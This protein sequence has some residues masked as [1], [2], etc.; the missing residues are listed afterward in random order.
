MSSVSFCQFLR[1]KIP[2]IGLHIKMLSVVRSAMSSFIFCKTSWRWTATLSEMDQEKYLALVSFWPLFLPSFSLFESIHFRY[3]LP[4]TYAIVTTDQ[5]LYYSRPTRLS[6]RRDHRRNASSFSMLLSMSS[7]LTQCWGKCL[8]TRQLPVKFKEEIIS[9]YFQ[10]KTT[11]NKDEN[12]FQ[13][14][15]FLK[16]GK[17]KIFPKILI[18][19]KN[20]C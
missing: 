14:W 15:A 9:K 16:K 2:I 8:R 6:N 13:F 11:R 1:L 19:E 17:G 7:T 3:L 18:N 4:V 12:Q 5:W 20:C 10:Q